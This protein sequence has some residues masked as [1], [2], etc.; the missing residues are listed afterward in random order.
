MR[1]RFPDADIVQDIGSSLNNQRQGLKSILGRCV[2]GEKPRLVVAHQERLVR[3]GFERIEWLVP[4]C[5]SELVVLSA[6][7]R[8][9]ERELAEDLLAIVHVFAGKRYGRRHDKSKKN[10]DEANASARKDT[11]FMDRRLL[12]RLQRNDL[13]SQP[14]DCVS[15]LHGNK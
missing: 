8:E 5:G 1:G 2:R 15:E 3:F 13:A 4:E 7:Q 14:S 6:D 10:Q 9:P 11:K 12:V